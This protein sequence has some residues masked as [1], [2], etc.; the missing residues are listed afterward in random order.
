MAA[1]RTVRQR[2][3]RAPAHAPASPSRRCT[4]APTPVGCGTQQPTAVRLRNGNTGHSQRVRAGACVRSTATVDIAC[5]C[6]LVL[7]TR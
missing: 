6:S 3:R 5:E 4:T 7:D 2:V 1:R